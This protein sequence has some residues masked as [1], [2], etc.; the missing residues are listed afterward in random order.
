MDRDSD[1]IGNFAIFI[2]RVSISLDSDNMQPEVS[3]RN[4]ACAVR[5]DALTTV[6]RPWRRE[7]R[8]QILS[9][10][11]TMEHQGRCDPRQVGGGYE[12]GQAAGVEDGQ[13]DGIAVSG[14]E[15]PDEEAV[16]ADEA[17]MRSAFSAALLSGGSSGRSRKRQRPSQ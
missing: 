7:S 1:F 11:E 17:L 14:I 9:P 3:V 5:S 6:W 4:P 2:L 13:R 10:T 12:A 16:L 15:R 8:P